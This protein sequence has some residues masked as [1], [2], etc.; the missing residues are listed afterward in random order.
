MISRCGSRPAGP[1]QA[2]QAGKWRNQHWSEFEGVWEGA[3]GPG[4]GV[5]R[6]EDIAVHNPL[7][8]VEKLPYSPSYGRLK[9]WAR[10][11]V[12]FSLEKAP[13]GPPSRVA[14]GWVAGGGARMFQK[15][16]KISKH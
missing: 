10:G 2:P 16:M 14:P 11:K 7:E 13:G 8:E 5:I 12:Y 1:Q 6:L 9:G 4:G 3:G 15:N